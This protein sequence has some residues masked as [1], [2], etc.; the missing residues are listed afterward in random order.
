MRFSERLAAGA[1][2]GAAGTLALDV[3]TYADMVTRGRP[4]SELPGQAA[5]QL[6]GRVGVDLSGDDDASKHRRS[7]LGALLGYGTGVAVGIAWTLLRGT[8]AGR[9]GAGEA[10]LVGAVALAAANG[11]M[12]AQG[13]TDPREW[14]VAGWVSDL[15]PHV[16]YG[17]GVV[18]ALRRT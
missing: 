18:A 16:A 2:A 1:V 12:I 13:L 11:P 15:V 17:A 14:G 4:A 10:L 3:A 6:A 5:A 7:A 9:G 8:R